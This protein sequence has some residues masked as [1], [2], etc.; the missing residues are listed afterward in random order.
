MSFIYHLFITEDP[1]KN[2]NV[3]YDFIDVL[4]L[5]MSALFQVLMDGRTLKDRSR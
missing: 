5:T 4:F 2:I 1:R 3:K